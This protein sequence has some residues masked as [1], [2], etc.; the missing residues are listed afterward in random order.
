MTRWVHQKD[1][2]TL[3]VQLLGISAEP[4]FAQQTFASSVK[5]PYPLLSDVKEEVI[6][7]YGVVYGTIPGYKVEY[8]QDVGK[9]AAR[10]FFL[11]DLQG[12]VRGRWW[13]EDL[14]VFPT[15]TLIKAAREL[16]GKP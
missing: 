1:F 4:T 3:G 11:I 13:G 15:E 9:G 5:L 8:P 2:E 16:A 14:A 12:I 6:K 10:V 7:R